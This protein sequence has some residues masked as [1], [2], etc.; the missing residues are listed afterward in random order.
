MNDQIHR[1]LTDSSEATFEK[2]KKQASDVTRQYFGRTISLYA[3]LYLGNYCENNCVYCGFSSHHKIPRTR[4][5][6]DELHKE[7]IV[8]SDQGIQN[9]LLLT[10]ESD[11]MTSV[12]Y[13]KNAVVIARHYFPNISIEIQPLSMDE[14]RELIEAGVDGLAVYQETYD[15]GIYDDVHV[16][17]KKKDYDFRYETPER[18]AHAGMRGP[19]SRRASLHRQFRE[20]GRAAVRP[21]R[22]GDHHRL[23]GKASRRAGDVA[24]NSSVRRWVARIKHKFPSVGG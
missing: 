8:L 17:G 5:N 14:Y 23:P 7:M 19:G 1:I 11:R 12:A 9:I 16:S 10:G 6:D 3:P 15:R 24:E 20:R 13:I 21:G 18:A 2:L 22:G 4:L